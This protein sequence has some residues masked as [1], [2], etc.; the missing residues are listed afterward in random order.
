[1]KYFEKYLNTDQKNLDEIDISVHC[2]IVIFDWLM[3][4]VHRQKPE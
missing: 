1:M 4:F 3:K 2:D